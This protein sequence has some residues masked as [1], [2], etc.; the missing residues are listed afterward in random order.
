MNKLNISIKL[1]EVIND[2]NNK[3]FDDAL[4]KLKTL[5]Q[6]YKN[7][8]LINK[9]FATIYFKKN[10]WKNAIKYYEKILSYER[11]KFKF[12]NNIGVAFFKLGE[13]TRSI[14]SYKKA[15]NDNY[16][17]DLAHTNLGISYIEIGKY[18]QAVNSFSS[19]LKLNNK[20]SYAQNNLIDI[21]NVIKPKNINDHPLI[22]IN[23]EINKIVNNNKIK[24]LKKLEN[25]KKILHDSD[26]IIKNFDENLF[27]NETQIYRKNSKNLNCNR[28]F[29]I[30][31]KFNIIPKFCFSCYKIQI[32]LKNIVDLIKLYFVFDNLCLKNNNIRKCIVEIRNNIKGNY[33]GYI[34]CD[35]LNEAQEI[36][37]K[38]NKLLDFN[39]ISSSKI[40][41]KHGCSEFYAKYPKYEKINFEGTQEMQYKKEWAKKEYIFDSSEISR[42]DVDKK[43]WSSYLKGINLSDILIIKNWIKYADT[44]GDYSYKLVYDKDIKDNFFSNIIKTQLDFR[45]KD[46]LN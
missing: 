40:M 5:S 38:I 13:I 36:T 15:I 32:N 33:K 4:R 34:Y 35:K 22:N 25:I 14:E 20:N 19:A 27:T 37:K 26:N 12:Y 43:V 45:K 44:I 21:F 2:L 29:K 24:D 41:I 6:Q 11:E 31:N 7:N 18:E 10:N 16:D 30:F 1:K 3:T 28:H 9:L 23:N 46:L 8:H 39:K 42:I 17:F